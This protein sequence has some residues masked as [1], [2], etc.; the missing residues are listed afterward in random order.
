[1]RLTGRR[2]RG[3]RARFSNHTQRRQVLT[4]AMARRS[5]TQFVPVGMRSS[6]P[7]QMWGGPNNLRG[8][9]TLPPMQVGVCVCEKIDWDSLQGFHC[10]WWWWWCVCILLWL[11]VGAD[12]RVLWRLFSAE[13][14]PHPALRV[15]TANASSCAGARCAPLCSTQP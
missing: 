11:N 9:T 3:T 15:T 13:P 7:T 2:F 14:L 1:M 12:D 6:S 8:V 5:P 4:A 10:F